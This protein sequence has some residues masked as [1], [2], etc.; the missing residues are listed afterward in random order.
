MPPRSRPPLKER[1]YKSD[2][3]ASSGARWRTCPSHRR[4]GRQQSQTGAGLEHLHFGQV[5]ASKGY[6]PPRLEEV[7]TLC[8][9]PLPRRFKRPGPASKQIIHDGGL[10]PRD[11]KAGGYAQGL[12]EGRQQGRH[13]CRIWRSEQN[14]RRFQRSQ[15]EEAGSW[16]ATQGDPRAAPPQ[17]Q[18]PQENPLF[19]QWSSRG[20]QPPARREEC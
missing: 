13:H 5:A 14:L 2:P 7:N 20:A 9:F 15:N 12:A 6:Q 11:P 16:Q 8:P 18:D 10:K 3:K 1:G 4:R 19:A 17:W